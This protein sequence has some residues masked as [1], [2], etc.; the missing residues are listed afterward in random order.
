MYL[1]R[2]TRLHAARAL[3][4]MT[5]LRERRHFS[6][7]L[8]FFFS[9]FFLFWLRVF[10]LSDHGYGNL[11][12]RTQRPSC[13]SFISIS[14]ASSSAVSVSEELRRIR[15]R[16]LL[17]WT[18]CSLFPAGTPLY[19]AQLANALIR[20]PCRRCQIRNNRINCE[21]SKIFI[22]CLMDI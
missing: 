2:G 7:F 5:K 6:L 14:L 17:V 12:R 3:L 19:R 18:T 16:L 8:S 9:P 1:S 15:T 21:I 13:A 11:P 4:L 22:C 10:I 20:S